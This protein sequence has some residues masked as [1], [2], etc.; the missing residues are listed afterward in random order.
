MTEIFLSTLNGKQS[1]QKRDISKIR[2]VPYSEAEERARLARERAAR[3]AAMRRREELE[4]QRI[5]AEKKAEEEK[6]E[7]EQ[8]A[9][10][11]A[12]E[13]KA[14]E[15]AELEAQIQADKEREAKEKAERAAAL[16]TLVD[17]GTFENDVEEPISYWDFTWRSILVPG[18]GHFY[19]DRPIMGSFYTGGSLLL[20]ANAYSQYRIARNALKENHREVELNF[21]MTLQPDLFSKELRTYYSI[22]ANAKSFTTYQKKVDRFNYSVGL[23]EIFYG[24]QLLHIIYNGIAWENGLLIVRNESFPGVPSG[25]SVAIL[26]D[27]RINRETNI[28]GRARTSVFAGL[29]LMF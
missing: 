8:A 9:L 13:Q 29:R 4:R 11:A 19:I 12:A 18:W 24:V 2:Y 27:V 7:Q 21:L 16:R 20:A 17:E 25:S 22:Q 23:L 10:K 3:I 5:E 15:L 28:D 1:V 26:P 14:K 6:K